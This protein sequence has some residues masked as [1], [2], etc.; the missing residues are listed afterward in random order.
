[1]SNTTQM[2]GKVVL[3]TGS[4]TGLGLSTARAFGLAGATVA[5]TD[6]ELASA[7]GAADTLVA[8]GIDAHAFALDVRREAHW[9]RVLRQLE[10]RCGGLDVLV[11]NAGV[12]RSAPLVET[13]LADWRFVTQVNLDGVFLGIKFGIGAISQHGGGAIVNVASILGTVGTLNNAAYVAA[14]GGVRQLSKAAALECA[15]AGNGIRVNCVLPGYVEMPRAPAKR[16]SAERRKQLLAATPMA[17]FATPA[18]IA[19]AIV[20]LAS[21]QASYITGTDLIVDGGFTAL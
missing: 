4:A 12:G 7:R 10:R 15:A 20:Y 16:M 1:M 5:I 18:E 17:R 13:S 9:P 3:V 14:K 6:L 19:D 2:S 8:E 11:N 21:P